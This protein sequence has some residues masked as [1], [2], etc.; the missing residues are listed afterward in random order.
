M[1]FDGVAWSGPL[2]AAAISSQP[3]APL[4]SDDVA[5]A[6]VGGYF[7][8][9]RNAVRVVEQPFPL[10]RRSGG[11]GGAGRWI[12]SLTHEDV[13]SGYVW[14][15]GTFTHAV[16]LVLA[17]C[18]VATDVVLHVRLAATDSAPSTKVG[19]DYELEVAANAAVVGDAVTG[20]LDPNA[21][22]TEQLGGGLFVQ[23][24]ELDLSGLVLDD[25]LLL[26]L[27]GHAATV[28]TAGYYRPRYAAI[29]LEC[30]G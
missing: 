3:H 4:V 21:G 12:V 25:R 11:D 23:T 9:R 24:A 15:E 18:V 6:L 28:L 1:V 5:A 27:E 19:D 17:E 29:Y 14:V 7:A 26:E 30:R 16:G 8:A 22:V 2:P 20:R 10:L 13:A